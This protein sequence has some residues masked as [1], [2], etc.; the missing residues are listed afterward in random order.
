M[1]KTVPEVQTSPRKF[2]STE[3]EPIETKFQRRL[4]RDAE[5]VYRLQRG[6][7]YA[8]PVL[9]VVIAAMLCIFAVV[10]LI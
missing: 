4:R 7:V 10:K 6:P 8:L 9:A 5:M 2:N 1:S 3:A